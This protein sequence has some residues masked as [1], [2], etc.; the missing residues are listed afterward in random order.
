MKL[1]DFAYAIAQKVFRELVHTHHIVISEPIEKAVLAKVRE[2]LST[3]IK[4]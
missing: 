1:D 3:L 2:E 4:K